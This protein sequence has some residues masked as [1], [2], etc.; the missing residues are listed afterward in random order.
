MA[1]LLQ[2]EFTTDRAAG[3]VNGTAAEPGPGGNTHGNGYQ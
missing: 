3:A 2:D 1:Y